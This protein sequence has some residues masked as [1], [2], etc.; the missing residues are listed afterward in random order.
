[1][2]S[3]ITTGTLTSDSAVRARALDDATFDAEIRELRLLHRAGE[4]TDRQAALLIDAAETAA[5]ARNARLLTVGATGS[6][7]TF[8]LEQR[9]GD[10]HDHEVGEIR[11]LLDA[12]DLL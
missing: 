3:T 8:E 5:A 9:H 2:F 7:T 4:L 11:A 10:D 12:S 6:L 1:M